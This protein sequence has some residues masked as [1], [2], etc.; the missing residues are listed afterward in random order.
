M[1]IAVAQPAPVDEFDAELERALGFANEFALVEA[2]R[3]VEGADRRDRRLADADGADFL[4]FDQ[5]DR[6]ILAQRH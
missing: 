1:E 5:G 4:G 2:E 3:L 6:A